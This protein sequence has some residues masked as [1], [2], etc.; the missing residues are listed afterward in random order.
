MSEP[1]DEVY[2]H[3]GPA[4]A[5]LM[6]EKNARLDAEIVKSDHATERTSLIDLR[7]R[8]ARL[9][10]A[11]WPWPVVKALSDSYEYHIGLRDGSTVHFESAR[12]DGSPKWVTVDPEGLLVQGPIEQQLQTAD[13]HGNTVS[14][15]RGLCLRV[16]EIVWAVDGHE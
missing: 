4:I 13:V 10:D 11:G 7:Q 15:A 14:P 12:C 16:S 9:D 1:F 8:E 3:A 6:R 2:E 5:D